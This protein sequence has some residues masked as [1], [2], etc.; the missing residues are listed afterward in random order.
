[1]ESGTEEASRE[2]GAVLAKAGENVIS[3]PSKRKLREQD[4]T[5]VAG[6]KGS[7]C[8]PTTEALQPSVEQ[9]KAKPARVQH[10]NYDSDPHLASS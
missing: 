9:I 4:A 1:M 8:S 6:V 2:T 3:S 5:D 7:F 10:E